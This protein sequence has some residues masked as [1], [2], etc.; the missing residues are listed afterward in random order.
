VK[1]VESNISLKSLE[2]TYLFE[3]KYTSEDQ[4]LT[5]DVA[6][7][8]ANLFIAFM[9]RVRA[10]EGEYLREHLKLQLEQSRQQLEIA[11]QKLEE[12]KKAHSVFLYEQ[13]YDAKLKVLSE[14]EVE[15]AKAEEALAGSQNS[16]LTL[17]LAKKHAR[18]VSL[19][20]EREAALVPLPQIER[21]LK[22]LDLA[23]K[24]A[25]TAYEIV[26]KEVKE[27]EIK[28]SYNIPE[29]RL[30]SQAVVPRL[31]SSPIPV[32]IALICFLGGLVV[33]VGLSFFLEYLDRRVRD[34]HDIE[35]SIGV[36]V[37]ATIPRVSQRR[38]RHAG[39]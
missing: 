12:Y 13:E 38:W 28:Y 11:R 23:V 32:K 22:Q 8:T 5:A 4:Q 1:D 26:D 15:L 17:S 29:V 6:N 3:I 39:L 2:D 19:I 35:D 25:F 9:E 36:K 30:V 20:R 10:S 31:P 21:E 18:L 16:L 24:V 34:I 37:L 33:A 14:L 27:A 7:T